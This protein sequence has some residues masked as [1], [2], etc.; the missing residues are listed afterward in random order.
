MNG[1][2]TLSENIAD[3]AGLAIA[4]R[5]WKLS[6]NGKP[7]PIIDGLTGDQRFFMGWTQRRRAN[8]RDSEIIRILKSDEHAPFSIRGTVPLMNH[9]AFYEAFDVKP[10]DKMYLPPEKRVAIW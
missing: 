1:E 2:Q 4:Y 6:L 3:N 5:A 7:A 8:F 10:S 9:P